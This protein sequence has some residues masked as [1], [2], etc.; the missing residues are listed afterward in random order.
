MSPVVIIGIALAAGASL[1]S[2]IKVMTDP[3]AAWLLLVLMIFSAGL[4]VQV[5]RA[6]GTDN[7]TWLQP[8]QLQRANLYFAFGGLLFLG[9]LVHMGKLR[10]N[11]IPMQGFLLMAIQFVAGMLRFVH[12]T[13]FDAIS[14]IASA[15]VT[16]LPIMLL[17]PYALREWEDWTRMIRIFAF[18]ALVWGGAVAVQVVLDH[19]QL[20]V[21]WQSRFTG[22]LGNP[23][24]CGLYMAPLTVALLWLILNESSAKL[25]WL[26]IFTFGMMGV[27]SMWTGS[28]TCILVT[29]LGSMFVLYSRMGRAIL[30]LPVA[31]VGLYA[32]LLV[33][34]ALG[35]SSDAIERLGSQQN[36]RE[37][38]WTLLL[39]DA[40]QNPILGSGFKGTRANENSYL[41][42]FGAYGILGGGLVLALTFYSGFLMLKVFRA[43]SFLPP[44]RKQIADLIL[45]FN[46]VFF[47]GA[48][49]EWY[50]IARLEGMLP[51]MLVFSVMTKRLLERVEQGDTEDEYVPALA[52]Q[53]GSWRDEYQEIAESYGEE[54]ADLPGYSKP[55]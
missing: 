27:Y 40:L 36:T 51:Y 25:R 16:M 3:K 11:T 4:A 41:V 46:A 48:M 6:G 22:L 21:G 30:L 1:Y 29:G 12:E 9:M 13:P 5:D 34:Q 8:L 15:L 52:E 18:A 37:V 53:S 44:G 32:L 19:R 33:A 24:G 26:W 23:Q 42:S 20:I 55:A 17:L 47:L 31:A 7:Q 45:G 54:P 49:F 10:L 38:V 2:F 43:R 28:R 50:I 14:T 39:E 35:L